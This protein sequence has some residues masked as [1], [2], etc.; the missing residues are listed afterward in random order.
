MCAQYT[1]CLKKKHPR[2]FQLSLENQLTD[3]DNFLVLTFW[4][5]L[6]IK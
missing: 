3:S 5:Q 4:T 6:A 2:H 1:L